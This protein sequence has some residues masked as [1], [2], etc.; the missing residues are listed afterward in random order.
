MPTPQKE[1][2]LSKKFITWLNGFTKTYAEKRLATS[3]RKGR[4]DI[5]GCSHGYRLEIE[6]K[7][8]DNKPTKIQE[9]WLH[10]WKVAGAIS[11]WGNTLENLQHQF[12]TAI[13]SRGITIKEKKLDSNFVQTPAARR[14]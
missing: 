2:A 1:S 5:T 11:F 7:I 6:V 4:L 13:A 9:Y 14:S 10:K 12:L 3:G 8:G